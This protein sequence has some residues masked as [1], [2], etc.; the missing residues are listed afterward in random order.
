M[1]N[2]PTLCNH[3]CRFGGM[4]VKGFS[5]LSPKS[6]YLLIFNNLFGGIKK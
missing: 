1:N 4:G 6:S 5:H 2:I 3:L